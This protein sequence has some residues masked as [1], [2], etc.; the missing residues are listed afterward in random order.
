VAYGG[1]EPGL[2]AE[3][4]R[5]QLGRAG[6]DPDV[7]ELIMAVIGPGAGVIAVVGDV[8]LFQVVG[9]QVEQVG[10]T[11]IHYK[12]TVVNPPGTS[13]GTI[14]STLDSLY[15][16][17]VKNM[18]CA[19]ATYQGAML[20]RVW[21]LPPSPPAAEDTS[22]GPGLVAG[23]LMP[24]QVAGVVS[25]FTAIAGRAFRGRAYTFFP[26]E[27][28]NTANGTPSGAYL[29]SL[30]ALASLMT[31]THVI[32]LG[33]SVTIQPVLFHRGSTLDPPDPAVPLEGSTTPIA[34][35]RRR[36][37]WGTQRKRGYFGRPNTP[38][39]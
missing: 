19:A 21:P 11:G 30:D 29:T 25:K 13:L 10:Y 15:A 36:T 14:V 3:L 9:V 39:F 37:G 4:F 38:P 20:R 33:G 16:P 26:S 8:L 22:R 18:L 35:C 31:Q 5:E 6:V 2:E 7:R 1:A 28:S 34:G 24:R 23:E 12:V 27:D 32:A 17:I